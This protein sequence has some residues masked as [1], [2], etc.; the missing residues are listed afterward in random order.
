MS[1]QLSNSVKARA[2]SNLQKCIVYVYH[3]Y[4]WMVYVLSQYVDAEYTPDRTV[5]GGKLAALRSNGLA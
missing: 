3:M 5:I 4:T 1:V 2:G